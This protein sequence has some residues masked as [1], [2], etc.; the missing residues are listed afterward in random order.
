MGKLGMG[1]RDEDKSDGSEH[2]SSTI[3]TTVQTFKDE[4]QKQDDKDGD[5][6]MVSCS[7]F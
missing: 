2:Y 6:G 1:Y 7:L 4:C 5:L 3:N